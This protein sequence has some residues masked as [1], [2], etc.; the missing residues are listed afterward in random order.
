VGPA[1]PQGIQGERGLT[2]AVGP[3][4]PQGERGLQG[5]VGPA[6]PQG[7]VGPAGPQGIQ[8][9]RGLQ[10]VQGERGLQGDVGP[11][12]PAGA[13]GPQ[14]IQ[15]VAGPAGA[16]GIP[17]EIGPAGPAGPQG[18]Q[19]VQG[20]KGDVGDRYAATS[21]S[22]VT[23]GTGSKTLTLTPLGL[24]YTISQPVLIATSAGV[25]HGTVTSY[26]GTTGELVA[27][28]TSYT[29]SGSSADWTV[30]LE[31]VAGAQGPQGPAGP[32]GATGPAGPAGADG[33]AG[34]QGPAGE[35]GPQGATGPAGAVGPAGP[36][37]ER[38]LQGIQGEVGPQGATGPQ[39][40]MGTVNIVT[41][42]A[43]TDLTGDGTT[44]DFAI[45]GYSNTTAG[46]YM[47]S[48]GGIDQRP[49]TDWTI[50]S[51]NGGTISFASAPP[52]GAAIIVRAFTGASGGGGSG[53]ATSL[54]GRALA[55]TAPT[56]GQAIVWDQTG[57]TWKPG[58][59]SGG[60]PVNWLGTWSDATQYA[61]GDGV[62]YNGSSYVA[63]EVPPVSTLP[64]YAAYW[65]LVAAKGDTGATG[66]QGPSVYTFRGDWSA[67]V[68]NYNANDVV[69]Y[70]GASYVAT[71][72]VPIEFYPPLH[73][74]YWQLLAAK[75]DV[76][77]TGATGPQ[78]PQ[79]IAGQGFTWR[80]TWVPGSTYVP[81]DVVY[82]DAGYAVGA[83]ICILENYGNFSPE[84]D[85]THW[86][87]F[88]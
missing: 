88:A 82:Q 20:P 41:G 34:P 87:R 38:G 83:Y 53:D 29:G 14:G 59:V 35:M 1:G 27:N 13:T 75:G 58:T 57:A 66:A 47:V 72:A 37:G 65:Q 10:G 61:I 67:S 85:P 77:A 4:G 32:Q 17:G 19:G 50:T 6:G 43:V 84:S 36:Q 16:Q 39:G 12:G 28:V 46:N 79:G 9:E 74:E 31:G 15:G 69:T 7:Q 80:G 3:A 51:A 11:A 8:G 81:Y 44:T 48:V 52:A 33:Q 71:Q 63:T 21:T 25:M 18:I 55:N 60:A 76:G 62:A 42:S 70:A 45:N 54:Q 68:S 22:T 49:T 56:D 64:T 73:T 5:D 24:A 23:L 30:N 78:G 2:G 40:P 26:N 86:N